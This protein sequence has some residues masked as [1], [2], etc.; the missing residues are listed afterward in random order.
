M[1]YE[2]LLKHPKWQK[3]R[4]KIMERDNWACTTCGEKDKPLNVH[5]RAYAKD[6]APWEYP[7][8]ALMTVCDDCHDKYHKVNDAFKKMSLSEKFAFFNKPLSRS[9]VPIEK[10]EYD[11]F[12]IVSQPD[13]PKCCSIVYVPLGLYASVGHT[14]EEIYQHMKST[15]E[16]LKKYKKFIIDQMTGC[17]EPE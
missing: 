13:N 17:P 16:A 9:T 5:H 8:H 11:E 1:K 12:L 15:P 3:R 14:V 6:H 4:L 2:D 10:R 7:D